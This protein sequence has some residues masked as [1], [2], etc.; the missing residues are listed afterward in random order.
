MHAWYSH[1]GRVGSGFSPAIEDCTKASSSN[2]SSAMP[3]VS[4]DLESKDLHVV[5]SPT[6]LALGLRLR[7]RRPYFFRIDYGQASRIAQP[8]LASDATAIP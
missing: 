2:A 6:G 4:S 1:D 7:L 3:S 5:G 8:L